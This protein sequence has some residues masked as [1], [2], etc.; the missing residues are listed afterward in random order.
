MKARQK[1]LF[2]QPYCFDGFPRM[3]L[4]LMSIARMVDR[5]QFEPVIIDANLQEDAL[6][7]LL[8]CRRFHQR[9]H[10]EDRRA[11]VVTVRMGTFAPG[12]LP[13]PVAPRSSTSNQPCMI[14][15]KECH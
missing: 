13:L 6:D 9:L 2:Y 7:R 10:A 3:P 4:P 11:D 5:E 8:R 12:G 1:V 15:K 14:L